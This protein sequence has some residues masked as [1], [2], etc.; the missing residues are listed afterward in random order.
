MINKGFISARGFQGGALP[1]DSSRIP[2]AVWRDL[3]R[4]EPDR[5]AA[6]VV[7]LDGGYSP[8]GCLTPQERSI[9][10]QPETVSAALIALGELESRPTIR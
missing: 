2:H 9:H 3:R 4:L 6:I 10:R 5:P 8:R 1:P 7:R